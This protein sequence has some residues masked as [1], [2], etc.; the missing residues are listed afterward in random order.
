MFKH[1]IYFKT[2]SFK[3]NFLKERSAERISNEAKGPRGGLYMGSFQKLLLT[4][5]PRRLELR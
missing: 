1:A 5:F 2:F 3:S 4:A